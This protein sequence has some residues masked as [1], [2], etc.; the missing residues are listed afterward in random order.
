MR[1]E[2]CV[3]SLALVAAVSCSER[4]EELNSFGIYPDAD[5]EISVD[6]T[7]G[8]FNIRWTAD[9][10]GCLHTEM[11]SDTSQIL[12]VTACNEVTVTAEGNDMLKGCN[13]RCE[14][15]AISIRRLSDSSFRLGFI[16]DSD[17]DICVVLNAGNLEHH[18]YVRAREVIPVEQIL[19]DVDG[20]VWTV[21][22]QEYRGARHY[23]PFITDPDD[24][25]VHGDAMGYS[26]VSG[27]PF[28]WVTHNYLASVRIAGFRPENTSM[29]T[30][31]FVCTKA[32][33]YEV[34][35]DYGSD[36]SNRLDKDISAAM[37]MTFKAG[38]MCPSISNFF[39]CMDCTL[40]AS[41]GNGTK[42]RKEF[43]CGLMIGG[44]LS[45]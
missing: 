1:I 29:R 6:E 40:S 13:C 17:E 43:V 3:L 19:V 23:K 5:F 4:L 41:K 8:Q 15:G 27:K 12:Y 44:D 31:D 7:R 36:S 37:G 30:V 18:F 21:D 35:K 16:S 14:P 28:V 26:I 38:C 11:Q 20:T 45:D 34:E 10:G 25:S 39:L 24:G 33:W 32:R 22:A 9:E 2:F 42:V